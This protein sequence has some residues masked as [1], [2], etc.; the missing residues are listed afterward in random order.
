MKNSFVKAIKF[1]LF[2]AAFF[3]ALYYFLEWDALGRF[4]MSM[5]HSRLERIGMR[6]SYSDVTG[7]QDGFTVNNLSLNGMANISLSSVTIRPKLA[8]SILSLAPV[9]E[10]NFRGAN[11][12]LGQTLNLGDGGFLLTAGRNEILL[13]NLTTNG[14]FA[15]NGFLTVNTATMKLGRT[16]ARLNVPESFAQNMDMLK[17]FLPLVQDNGRWYLRRR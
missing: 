3:C 9:C 12:R 7:E 14:D 10:I 17:N 1:L 5:A 4:A 8:A 13:E 6:M 11:V 15:L 2:I 16:E